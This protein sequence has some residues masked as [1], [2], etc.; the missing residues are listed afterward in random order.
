MR[1]AFSLSGA[2]LRLSIMRSTSSNELAGTSYVETWSRGVCAGGTRGLEAFF[3]LRRHR[4]SGNH[5]VQPTASNRSTADSASSATRWGR[6]LIVSVLISVVVAIAIVIGRELWFAKPH[7][8]TAIAK[9][10]ETASPDVA[11]LLREI[12][13][14]VC[15]LVERYPDSP[16]ALDVMARMHHFFGE[17]DE[18]LRYWKECLKI[19]PKFTPAYHSIGVM[20]LEIG[21]HPQAVEYFRKGW[22]L[23]PNSPVFSVELAQALVASGQVK[24][25]VDVL[26]RDIT[27][28]PRSVGSL[29]MLGHAYLQLRD[30]KAAR[31]YFERAIEV[32]PT[33]TNAYFGL[34]TACNNLGDKKAA[35]KY[36]A[37]LKEMKAQ[38]EHSHRA[39]L[40][41]FDDIE[42]VRE[43][44]GAVYT[45]TGNV[46][47][48]HSDPVTAEHCFLRAAELVPKAVPPRE[49]LAWLYVQE[50]RTKEAVKMLGELVKADPYDLSAMMTSGSLYAQLQMYEEAEASYRHAISLT[51]A[52]AGGYAALSGLYLQAG[53]KFEQ[54]LQLAQKAVALEPVAKYYFLL[55]NAYRANGKILEAREA[56]SKA[57]KLEPT[58][59]DYRRYL[60][61]YDEK[62]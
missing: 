23:E 15:Q 46:Y 27:I 5:A 14:V 22:K 3:M 7:I 35:K 30:Y 55:S 48:E 56:I 60:E 44:V 52:Q 39:M 26:R 37:K 28:H 61:F 36:A 49:V 6:L 40:K 2:A 57:V 59:A 42:R 4:S 12:D 62:P 21:K 33:Y 38:D 13:G 51:P 41:T 47:L 58:N 53:M 25:A 10:A 29:A 54:A 34:V 1:L 31:K 8:H 16:E 24:Q 43:K 17:T 18:A 45:A 50:G 32:G 19:D 11:A 20:F 9:A